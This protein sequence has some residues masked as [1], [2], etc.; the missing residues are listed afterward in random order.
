MRRDSLGWPQGL[1]YITPAYPR[2]FRVSGLLRGKLGRHVGLPDRCI[3]AAGAKAHCC[4][5]LCRHAPRAAGVRCSDAGDIQRSSG[6][7][8]LG[9]GD[10]PL[11]TDTTKPV[12]NHK[13][14]PPKGWL[15]FGAADFCGAKIS[16]AN[17]GPLIKRARE[18]RQRFPLHTF[19]SL[20]YAGGHADNRT[21]GQSQK[22]HSHLGMAFLRARR[23]SETR[24]GFAGASK[25]GATVRWTAALSPTC[26]CARR[27][28]K[29]CL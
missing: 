9:L 27:T 29:T 12:D 15:S 28:G 17:G 13:R 7:I 1:G 21:C 16:A 24:A 18:T 23:G 26:V 4:G 14:E 5:G 2:G 11:I 19:L 6:E 3:S 8:S 25:P 10:I 22:S 20:R